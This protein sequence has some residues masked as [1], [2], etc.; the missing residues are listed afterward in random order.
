MVLE[1]VV[2]EVVRTRTGLPAVW[3]VGGANT[4]TGDAVV[5]AGPCGEPLK[6]LYVRRSG[7]LA[8][9]QHALFRVLP[10]YLVVVVSQW[11]HDY[12]VSVRRVVDGHSGPVVGPEVASYAEGAWVIDGGQR[13][14]AL[15]GPLDVE[16]G[17][18]PYEEAVA[19]AVSKAACYHCRE[20]HYLQW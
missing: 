3:E 18:P 1:S 9:G 4:N 6:P 2:V 14:L 13:L 16:E 20:A 5:V 19:A 11:R 8:C 15:G 17:R 7:H 12:E 10:G